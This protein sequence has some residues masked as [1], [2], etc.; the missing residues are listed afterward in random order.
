[1]KLDYWEMDH[2]H[3]RMAM[4]D[5]KFQ[6][7]YN[8]LF[9]HIVTSIEER[10]AAGDTSSLDKMY[11]DVVKTGEKMD[12]KAFGEALDKLSSQGFG[13][14]AELLA[15]VKGVEN[16]LVGYFNHCDKDNDG[17][18][19]L[20]EFVEYCGNMMG[21]SRRVAIKFMKNE[22]QYLRE[23]SMRKNLEPQYVVDLLPGPNE[24]DFK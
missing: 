12:V 20:E 11:D 16:G 13:G 5:I 21:R 24:V 8:E 2:I 9:D 15:V 4:Y 14:A 19:V 7:I 3:K 23:L 10:R 1:M 6:E 18:I 22:D 17:S